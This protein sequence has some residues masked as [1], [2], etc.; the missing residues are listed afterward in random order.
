M[1]SHTHSQQ[2]HELDYSIDQATTV[3]AQNPNLPRLRTVGSFVVA[4][5]RVNY[6]I[7]TSGRL[8]E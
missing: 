3:Q 4:K 6:V 7:W 8:G 5:A 2:T 1:I